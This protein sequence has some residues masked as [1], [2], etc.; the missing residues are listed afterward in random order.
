MNFLELLISYRNSGKNYKKITQ[1]KIY[2]IKSLQTDKIYIGSTK[3]TLEKRLSGRSERRRL[4]R[5]PLERR[6][7]GNCVRFCIAKQNAEA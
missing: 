3:K 6:P 5:R 2:K 4:E 7:L 1:E